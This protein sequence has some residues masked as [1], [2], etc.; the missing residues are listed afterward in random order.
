MSDPIDFNN[1]IVQ[2][3]FEGTDG[4][5]PTTDL[6][7]ST[8]NH[9][10]V[11]TGSSD[12]SS[13]TAQFDLTS[14]HAQSSDGILFT[15]QSTELQIGSQDCCIEFFIRRNTASDNL[16]ALSHYS[17][18]GDQ[19][20]WGMRTQGSANL[21]MFW[22]SDGASAGS[23]VFTNISLPNDSAFHH[24]VICRRGT[25]LSHFTDGVRGS[26][27]TDSTNLHA[28][29]T[30]LRV[31]SAGGSTANLNCYVDGLRY[32]IGESIYDPTQTSLIVPT[33]YYGLP[34]EPRSF[35]GRRA[36]FSKMWEMQ[37]LA[38]PSFFGLRNPNIVT[39]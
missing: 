31:G 37:R 28:S 14:A 8:F 5:Q 22:T 12:I 26:T 33:S 1:V 15:Q 6:D 38:R 10:S 19:R 24:I 13:D 2:S 7:D 9:A 17:I 39:S 25:D 27:I 20:S 21:E 35:R 4:A 23:A 34:P 16:W 29:T 3:N 30:D 18:T 11:F 32:V 36:F